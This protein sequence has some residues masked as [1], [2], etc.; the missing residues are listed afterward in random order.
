MKVKIVETK[1]LIRTMDMYSNLRAGT[2]FIPKMS[3][4]HGDSGLGKTTSLTYLTN[5]L[6]ASGCQPI[7]VRCMATDTP[8]SF[9]ARIMKELGSEMLY[10]LRNSVDFIIERMNELQVP[11]FIDEADHIVGQLKTMETIR[12]LYDATEQP[13]MLV[14]MEQI[15]KRISHRK[16]IFNRI[17]EWVEFQPADLEDVN[18]F[19]TELLEG[20]ISVGEDLLNDIRVR[21]GGEIRRILI[22]LDKIEQFAMSNDFDYVDKEC[23]GDGPLFLEHGRRR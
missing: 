4:M 7:F 3:L 17:S 22:A 23:W 6:T 9:V 19:A 10:P 5:Q 21:T 8:S 2:D 14:G 1:N 11:L 20:G 15:A 16:Q 18:L 13:V 12:D